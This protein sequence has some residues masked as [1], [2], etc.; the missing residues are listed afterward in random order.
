M[1][2]SELLLVFER[3]AAVFVSKADVPRFSGLH[4]AMAPGLFHDVLLF[5]T[6]HFPADMSLT[7]AHPHG[8]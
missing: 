8:D 5:R 4:P 6:S 1:R 3:L 2:I 7:K